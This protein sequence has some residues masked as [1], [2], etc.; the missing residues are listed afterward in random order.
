MQYI[1]FLRANAALLAAGMLLTFSSGFGQTWFV[2]LFGGEFRQAF[3]LSHATFGGLYSL[4][5]LVGAAGLVW[6]GKRIDEADLRYYVVAVYA[7]LAAASVALALAQGVA[8]LF[9]A[10]VGLRLCGQSLLPHTAVTTMARTFDTARG[11]AIGTAVLGLALAQ[12]VLPAVGV[13]AASAVGWRIA[14]LGIAGAI[15]A[16][17]VPL[18]LLLLRGAP[19]AAIRPAAAGATG[20][21][22]AGGSGAAARGM[23]TRGDVLRDR[24]FWFLMPATLAPAFV[25]TGLLFHQVPLVEAKGWSLGWFAACF[26]AFAAASVASTVVL[27]PLIDRLG[28][29]RLAAGCLVPLALG[30][31]ALAIGDHPV[32]AL[33]FMIAGGMT[34]SAGHTVMNAVWAELYGVAHLGAIRAAVYALVVVASAGSPVLL[35]A[36]ID[37]GATIGQVVGGCVAYVLVAAATVPF[38]MRRYLPAA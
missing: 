26:T 33:V 9:A 30:G 5:T 25:I 17:L 34:S 11:K 27:G 2:A 7:G 32:T 21:S 20:G 13:A 15:V 18:V 23:W 19:G 1:T 22:D 10:F 31:T 3:G 36:V 35:G 16:G 4:A 38:A 14:W 28:A 8:L 12:A 6:L 37:A 29:T 24:R